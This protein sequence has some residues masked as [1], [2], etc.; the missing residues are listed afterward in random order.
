MKTKLMHND[1]LGSIVVTLHALERW[2]ERGTNESSLKAAVAHAMPY[3][4]QYDRRMLLSSGD[5]V[6]AMRKNGSKW[7][8]IT[9]LT[10]DQA[11]STMEDRYGAKR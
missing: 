9:V 1:H 7:V 5:A 6:F 11:I 4:A 3:G 10:M 8:M 2:K